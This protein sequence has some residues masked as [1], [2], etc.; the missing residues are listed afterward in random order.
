METRA[1]GIALANRSAPVESLKDA[2][3]YGRSGLQSH[4]ASRDAI[5]NGSVRPQD[6]QMWEEPTWDLLVNRA[7][8]QVVLL[9]GGL[10]RHA[11]QER[12]K[13][14]GNRQGRRQAARQP[15]PGDHG[16]SRTGR[17]AARG[18]QAG[19]PGRRE[20][21]TGTEAEPTPGDGRADRG[22]CF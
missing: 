20:E 9:L 17:P 5:I 1:L 6:A 3:H 12:T 8:A 16:A 22:G 14:E 10:S 2:W 21:Q 4:A 15:N 18:S 19:W 7:C 13:A 11:R